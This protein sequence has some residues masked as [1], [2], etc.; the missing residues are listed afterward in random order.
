[1]PQL[2][3]IQLLRNNKANIFY[4]SQLGFTLQPIE[5]ISFNAKPNYLLSIICDD[6]IFLSKLNMSQ[7]SCFSHL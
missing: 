1:M 7:G 4:L 2:D 6:A 5:K 3:I